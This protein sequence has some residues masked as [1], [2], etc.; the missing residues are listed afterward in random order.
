MGESYEELTGYVKGSTW[1]PV[2]RVS[3]RRARGHHHRHD[4]IAER[5]VRTK[6]KIT[7]RGTARE[8][9]LLEVLQEQ[10]FIVEEGQGPLPNTTG[11]RCRANSTQSLGRR[12]AG[13]HGRKE[14]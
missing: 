1:D 2:R 5:L 12:H 3:A 14:P 9:G 8:E 10:R 11:I 4:L 6:R 13:G 7:E